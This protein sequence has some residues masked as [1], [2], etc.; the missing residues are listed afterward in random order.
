MPVEP[1]SE[2]GAPERWAL[3]RAAP[4]VPALPAALRCWIAYRNVGNVGCVRSSDVTVDVTMEAMIIMGMCNRSI[5][6]PPSPSVPG[7]CR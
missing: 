4:A 2:T 5:P 3:P 7:A 1:L 6:I